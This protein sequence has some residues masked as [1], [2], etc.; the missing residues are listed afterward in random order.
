MV[1]GAGGRVA[2]QDL[3]ALE[4]AVRLAEY[5]LLQFDRDPYGYIERAL[6]DAYDA[7]TWRAWRRCIWPHSQLLALGRGA[8][9]Q[10]HPERAVGEAWWTLRGDNLFGEPVRS[11]VWADSPA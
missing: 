7:K 2:E 5:R 3:T 11:N 10:L 4:R 8:I 6:G 1:A 9:V